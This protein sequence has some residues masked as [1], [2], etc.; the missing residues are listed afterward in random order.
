MKMEMPGAVSRWQRDGGWF[1]RSQHALLVVELPDE[2]GIQAQVGMQQVASGGIGLNH[3]RMRPIMSAR[4]K[5]ARWSVGGP[6]RANLAGIVL[7]IGGGPETTVA[8]NR[9]HRDGARK[10]VGHQQEPSG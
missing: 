9:H 4:G 3:M 2:D 7:G 1:I 6:G 8:E 5:A 10:I